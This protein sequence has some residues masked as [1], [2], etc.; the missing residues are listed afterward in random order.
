MRRPACGLVPSSIAAQSWLFFA[1]NWSVMD[2]KGGGN[3]MRIPTYID[4]YPAKMVSKLASRLIERY[5]KDGDSVFD[6]FCGSCAVL[7]AAKDKNMRVSGVDVNPVAPL[8]GR[9]KLSGFVKEHALELFDSAL[10][11]VASS[12]PMVIKWEKKNF[13][14]SAA[15]IRKF[16]FIRAA[17][18]SIP[19]RQEPE[20]SAILLALYLSVRLCSRADQRSPK[21]FI[22]KTA[23]QDR[24]GIHYDPIKTT[25]YLIEELSYYYCADNRRSNKFDVLTTTDVS[26]KG[27]LK[28]LMKAHSHVITS[29]PYINAQDY[30][31]NFKLE[32]HILEDVLPFKIRDIKERFIGTERGDLM[33]GVEDEEV[34]ASNALVPQ[35]RAI[36]AVSVRHANVVR[37]YFCDM[38]NA[39]VNAISVLKPDG[40]FVLVCGDNLVCGKK[41]Q[42]WKIL[43]EIM[44][45]IGMTLF[46]SFADPI[47]DR[48]L[49]PKRSGHKGLIK[50][51]MVLAFRRDRV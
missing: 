9:V 18:D 47:K 1:R 41:I 7:V 20:Y 25:R 5:A 40:V 11:R 15:T 31:R 10:K 46:D 43:S 49:A 28:G 4:R 2:P 38:R 3:G 51:E 29:P 44:N 8:F 33:L 26:R 50:E 32:L 6:P 37:R 23:T 39:L 35:L 22:S 13:W 30:Y 16:E 45:G 12:G 14:F 42:T 48:M 24:R 17:V 27:A 21:P 36:E 19:N 34:I